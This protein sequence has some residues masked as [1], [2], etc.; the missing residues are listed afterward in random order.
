M[1]YVPL[2]GWVKNRLLQGLNYILTSPQHSIHDSLSIDLLLTC[3]I[4]YE[5]RNILFKVNRKIQSSIWSIEFSPFS[6]AKII[7]FFHFTAL[8]GIDG[9]PFSWLDAQK[10]CE[11]KRLID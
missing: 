6:V 2:T 1:E 7:F 9:L 4:L 11:S 10:G 3:I 5:L 8:N